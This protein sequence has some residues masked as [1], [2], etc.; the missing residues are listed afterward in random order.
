M[1][2]VREV[3]RPGPELGDVRVS[4]LLVE[5]DVTLHPVVVG[6]VPFADVDH[7]VEDRDPPPAVGVKLVDEGF[8]AGLREALAQGE[9]LVVVLF[10]DCV[11]V[12]LEEFGEGEK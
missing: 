11:C 5:E 2:K 7:G 1:H 4:C 8:H 3:R 6:L 10:F 9:V 12:C